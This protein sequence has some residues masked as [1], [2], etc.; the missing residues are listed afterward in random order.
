MP[1]ASA[2]RAAPPRP[3]ALVRPP[4]PGTSSGRSGMKAM[5]DGTF[6]REV[7]RERDRKRLAE[8]LERALRRESDRNS[9]SVKNDARN[10]RLRDW[11]DRVAPRAA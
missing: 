8:E 9:A 2:S 10:A 1:Q 3:T 6:A 11:E 4:A 7:E 5:L